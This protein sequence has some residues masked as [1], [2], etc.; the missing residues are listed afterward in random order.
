MTV[1]NARQNETHLKI[2]AVQ[3]IPSILVEVSLHFIH[4]E[5]SE[6]LANPWDVV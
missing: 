4:A 5:P 2:T 3:Y 6:L 1:T